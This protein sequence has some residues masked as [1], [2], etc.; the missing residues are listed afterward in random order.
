MKEKKG[1]FHKC[2]ISVF[3]NTMDQ[4]ICISSDIIL[5][6]ALLHFCTVFSS[7]FSDRF[8]T[9]WYQLNGSPLFSR[10]EI[11]H[12]FSYLEKGGGDG[13]VGFGVSKCV[14]ACFAACFF[15]VC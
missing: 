13:R 3:D 15:V 8:P 2:C 10:L 1:S 14:N 12:F 5:N 6:N 7:F 11:L 4:W 9:V